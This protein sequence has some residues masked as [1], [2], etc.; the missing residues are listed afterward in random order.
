MTARPPYAV[1]PNVFPF[2]ALAA[3]AGKAPLGGPREIALA[4]LVGARLASGC[5]EPVIPAAERGARAAAARSWLGSLNLPPG[6]RNAVTRVADA[7]TGDSGS[8]VAAALLK[9]ME[10]TAGQVD[11][12]ARLELQRLTVSLDA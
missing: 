11:G 7:S 9:V 6:I 1:A 4:C 8:A 2:P 3:L 5:I 12:H 10:V